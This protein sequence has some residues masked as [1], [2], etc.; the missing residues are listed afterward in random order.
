MV[1][2]WC[3]VRCARATCDNLGLVHMGS[4]V[5]SPTHVRNP[6]IDAKCQLWSLEKLLKIW[7]IVFKVR[8][9]LFYAKTF[10]QFVLRV[11]SYFLTGSTLNTSPSPHLQNVLP[12]KHLFHT[13]SVRT[14]GPVWNGKSR[15]S[16]SQWLGL[17]GLTSSEM[18]VRTWDPCK[19]ALICRPLDMV[20][21]WLVRKPHI[22]NWNQIK[23]YTRT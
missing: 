3:I 17:H 18:E 12:C 5:P 6:N 2:F 16:C 14:W 9:W 8:C 19:P 10:A 15:F 4:Q 23:I 1:I 20:S 21:R 11:G 13:L 22:L 7:F